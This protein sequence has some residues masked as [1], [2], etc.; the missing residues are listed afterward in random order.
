MDCESTRTINPAT[1]SYNTKDSA[2][3]HDAK[4]MINLQVSDQP[5]EEPTHE[6]H[7]YKLRLSK[8]DLQSL[9]AVIH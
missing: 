3:W 2:L 7:E 6:V 8:K 9:A 5:F 1:T 4:I